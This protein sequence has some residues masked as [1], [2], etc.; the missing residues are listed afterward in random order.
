QDERTEAPVEPQDLPEDMNELS[1]EDFRLCIRQW[2]EENYP[3]HLKRFAT[4]RYHRED[5]NAWYQALATKGWIAPGWPREYGGMGLSTSKRVICIQ[6]MDRSGATRFSYQGVV[7]VGPL[8]MNFGTEAPRSR[9]LPRILTGE[10]IWAQ[11]Y[12]EP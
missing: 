11:G 2:I 1:D 5:T 12:S 7:M 4:S 3:A 9:F 8:L 6:E 10:T